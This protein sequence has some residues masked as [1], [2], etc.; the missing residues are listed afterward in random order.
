MGK[1]DQAVLTLLNKQ[2]A[3][4]L[5]KIG[6]PTF[7]EKTGWKDAYCQEISFKQQFPNEVKETS[8]QRAICIRYLNFYA[9]GLV[10]EGYTA[11]DLIGAMISITPGLDSKGAN[12]VIWGDAHFGGESI[13]F[14][15]TPQGTVGEMSVVETRS[16][17][18]QPLEIVDRFAALSPLEDP[19]QSA[20]SR[21]PGESAPAQPQVASLIHTYNNETSKSFLDSMKKTIEQTAA[22]D[23][24]GLGIISARR[25]LGFTALTFMRALVKDA[26][27]MAVAF[28]KEQYR[29]NIGSLLRMVD[30]TYS[31]PCEKAIV[32]ACDAISNTS[33]SPQILFAKIVISW[34]DMTKTTNSANASILTATVI[35]H[36]VP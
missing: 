19:L 21:I 10:P 15:V 17:T 32:R 16:A 2:A 12:D 20:P 29:K 8:M 18:A 26:R 27:Q 30:I 25:L 1:S 6:K 28:A 22:T 31:P 34:S 11:F 33:E 13:L 24:Q 7:S 14:R 23:A 3:E 9:T 4:T 36:T 5:E 35:P